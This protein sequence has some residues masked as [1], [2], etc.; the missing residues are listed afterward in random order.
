MEQPIKLISTDFDG[1]IFAEFET[2]PIHHGLVERI[3]SLQNQGAYWIINTGREMA[4]LMESLGRANLHIQPDLLVL[5]EREIYQRRG[6]RY[7]P[8]AEWNQAC[9][10]DH[11]ALFAR[12]SQD[13]AALESWITRRFEAT[14]FADPHSPL[15]VIATNNRD[16]DKIHTQ[17][18]TICA[19]HPDLTVVRNDVYARFSHRSYNKGTALAK[20]TALLGFEPAHVFAAGDHLNDLPMLLA[21]YAKYLAAPSNATPEVLSQVKAQGG[22]LCGQ[23]HGFGVQEALDHYLNHPRRAV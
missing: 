20:I 14:V 3:A 19:Q 10:D 13:V 16:M 23:P 5:V 7:V 21:A 22:Y 1:T 17:L 8:L 6:H 2:P 12:V 9:E 18:D 15:C 4:S 11:Q